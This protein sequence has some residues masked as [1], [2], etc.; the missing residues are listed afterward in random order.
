MEPSTVSGA[1]PWC[2]SHRLAER[3]LERAARELRQTEIQ[4]LHQPGLRHHD[5]ARF[6]IAVDD[7]GR[8]RGLQS[9]GH[10]HRELQNL[11]NAQ[12]ALGNQIPRVL[13]W[14]YS[15]TM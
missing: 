1:G 15:I 8:V 12:A 3:G 14:T 10:L 5:V 6:Q 2:A 11:R 9:V 7:A 4:N 13:P